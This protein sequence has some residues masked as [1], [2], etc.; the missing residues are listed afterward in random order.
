M[1][2]N[3]SI[4]NSA[5]E[6]SA[7]GPPDGSRDQPADYPDG[8]LRRRQKRRDGARARTS[9]TRRRAPATTGVTLFAQVAST[10]QTQSCCLPPDGD[11]ATIGGTDFNAGGGPGGVAV[12]TSPLPL[13]SRTDSHGIHRTGDYSYI[14]PY[15]A[16][17]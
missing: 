7:G 11:I 4:W 9:K 2:S 1:P 3:R 6:V 17:H 13:N 10:N 12:Y 8:R 14:A 5:P 16:R 15:P